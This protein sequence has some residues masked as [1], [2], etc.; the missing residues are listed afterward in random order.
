MS[1]FSY[2]FYGFASIKLENRRTEQ[3]LPSGGGG[4]TDG[5]GR[6]E[7]MGKGVGE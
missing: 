4:G 1:C 7:V 2:Y 3:V 6:G 5:K